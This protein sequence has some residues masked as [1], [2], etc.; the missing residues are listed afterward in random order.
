MK[1]REQRAGAWII[2]LLVTLLASEHEAAAQS[3]VITGARM[4]WYGAFTVGRGRGAK[5]L[6]DGT[7]VQVQGSAVRPPMVNSDRIP[8][9]ADAKFGFGY[10]LIGEPANA[11]VRLRYVIKIP[12]PGAVDMASG[13]RKLTDEGAYPDLRLGRGDLFIGESLADFK[14]PPAGAWTVQLWHDD[15]MLL[16]RTFTVA[17]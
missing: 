12:P 1:V 9:S 5:D 4:T 6:G 3:V 7:G 14:D 16:E 8:F 11:H 2:G 13:S 10:V 15:H 17:K